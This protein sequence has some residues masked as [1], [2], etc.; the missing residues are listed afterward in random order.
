[1]DVL[2]GV[3]IGTTNI[4]C[5]ALAASPAGG[6]S[7]LL[8]QA[9][10][11][12]PA[13]IERPGRV[14]HEAEAL[15]QQS[16][17]VIRKVVCQ[18]AP[19]VRVIGLA[20]ASVGEAGVP[21]DSHD[22]PV[23]PIIAWYD[24]RTV[25]QADW[26]RR[27]VGECAIYGHTGLP[28]GHTFTLNKLMWLQTR[29]P[30]VYA[31]MRR[32]L[33]VADYVGFR[34]TGQ[35]AMGYSLASR[36][37]ALDLQ[38]HKWSDDMLS[39]ANVPA[40]VLPPLLPEGTRLGVITPEVAQALGL[41]SGTVVCVGG[42]DHVCG[43]LAMG[44]HEPGIV[45]DS[46]GTTEA[47]LTT[48]DD[49]GTHLARADL[50]FCLGCHVLP[51]RYYVIGSVLGAGSVI[52]WLA[53]LLWPTEEGQMHDTALGMLT[54]EGERS[55]TG[56]HGLYLLPHLAGAGSPERDSKAR[57]VLVGLGLSHTRADVARAAI[58]GLAFE[59][60]LLW[61]ALV[62]FTGRPIE[63]VLV[64]GG[65]ARNGLW[66]QIKADVTGQ[67]LSVPE[68]VEATALGAALLAGLGCG[69]YRDAADAHVHLG[70]RSATVR[71]QSDAR[72]VYEELYQG[73]VTQF[74]P[75]AAELG[76]RSGASE[77]T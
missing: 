77:Q 56:A 74:R 20:V 54:S 27:N 69:L 13:T 50:S 43:A 25:P 59:L 42:H 76:R 8:A 46:A 57:G 33:C 51:G 61:Q 68:Q 31:R 5:V 26:W 71:P 70:L 24:E 35:Q 41:R 67:V 32:W 38:A 18:L 47:Q 62:Q 40:S 37:M 64:V 73:I 52:H 22:D 34:L 75:L 6:D 29:E 36:T 10:A 9:S 15:W 66:N 1:M 44:V 23:Y 53:T 60:R 55:P 14:T 72:E 17:S 4:K 30:D 12:T 2:L 21:L 39:A 48:V 65:G 3:D 63:S 45:L 28:L 58:E 11:P 19:D 49:V 16:I 7:R